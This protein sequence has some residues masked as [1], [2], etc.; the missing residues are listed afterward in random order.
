VVKEDV[1]G[2]KTAEGGLVKQSKQVGDGVSSSSEVWADK[3]GFGSGEEYDAESESDTESSS[4]TVTRPLVVWVTR[5]RRAR[6]SSRPMELKSNVV[7]ES[8]ILPT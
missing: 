4:G 8:T 5:D 3:A 6:S 1:Q 7:S 2:S